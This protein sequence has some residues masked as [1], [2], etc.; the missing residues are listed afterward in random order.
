LNG[1]IAFDEDGLAS[2]TML[3]WSH[4]TAG[5]LGLKHVTTVR[6]R[7]M[8]RRRGSGCT[9]IQNSRKEEEVKE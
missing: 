5:H 8:K 6:R 1:L 3:N 4:N 9:P 7:L 2:R